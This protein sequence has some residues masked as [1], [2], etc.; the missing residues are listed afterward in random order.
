[1][2]GVFGTVRPGAWP[3]ELA[4]RAVE[5]VLMLGGLAE[6]RGTDAAGL[7]VAGPARRGDHPETTRTDLARF[8]DVRVDGWRVVKTRGRFTR[9]DPPGLVDELRRARLVLGH[10]RWATQGGH[11]LANTSPLLVGPLVG[12]HN[13]D[14]DAAALAPWLPR[15]AALRGDTDSE[16]LLAALAAADGDPRRLR[17]VLSA[18]PGR[19]ALAWAPRRGRRR[20]WL[21]R[22]ALSP[23]AVCGDRHGGLWWASNPDWLRRV[24]HTVGI[25]MRAPRMLRE[26]TLL[27]A[28]ATGGQLTI[29][30]AGP[31]TAT[32]R[33]RD[34]RLA[35]LVVWRGF[36]PADRADDVTRL[37][38]RVAT[39]GRDTPGGRLLAFPRRPVDDLDEVA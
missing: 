17:E 18:V 33:A 20:V 29:H 28:T 3:A 8:A 30:V 4:D 14:V 16:A 22:A 10:T 13:G 21:A 32:A 27:T 7:A 38:H 6:Q 35:E 39:T 9:L 25:G 37:R 12:T 23:L 31:F 19:A 24:E 26:G 34:V 5:A 1:M 36:T 15:S 11:R 2:C